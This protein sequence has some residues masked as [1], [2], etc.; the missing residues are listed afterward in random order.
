MQIKVNNKYK[1]VTGLL[2]NLHGQLEDIMIRA[3]NDGDIV[4]ENIVIAINSTMSHNL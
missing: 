4:T 3:F 2:S 1:S